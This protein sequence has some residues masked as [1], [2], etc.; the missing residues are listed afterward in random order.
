[1]VRSE[2]EKEELE[3]SKIHCYKTTNLMHPGNSDE[4]K[5]SSYNS[6]LRRQQ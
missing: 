1:M 3:F 4:Q 6:F 2:R 5:A